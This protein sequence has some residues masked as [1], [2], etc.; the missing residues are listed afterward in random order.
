ML[1]NTSRLGRAKP[2]LTRQNAKVLDPTQEVTALRSM[3]PAM[4]KNAFNTFPTRYVTDWN[5]WLAARP[6]ERTE[7][8]GVIL[9]RWQAARPRPMRRT[10]A[11]AA[12][13]PPYLDDLLVSARGPARTLGDLT[14]RTVGERTDRQD[15][16]LCRLWDIFGELTTIDRATSVGITKS[17]ML[18]TYGRI[19]PAF[20]SNVQARIGLPRPLTSRAWIES[21]ECIADDIAAYEAANGR[22][23]R[24]APRRFSTL[25]TGRLYDMLLGPRGVP[26]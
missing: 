11:A 4:V 25:E 20:D 6:S 3:T 19:G 8:F 18:V 23:S 22:L 10:R 15:A 16:A 2:R 26:G 13:K 1:G 17:I 14:V 12:H 21:L 7:L 24:A 9:R 5:L